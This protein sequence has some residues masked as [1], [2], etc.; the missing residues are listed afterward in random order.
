MPRKTREP[1]KRCAKSTWKKRP[2]EK[3]FPANFALSSTGFRIFNRV[4]ERFHRHLQ[5]TEHS[6]MTVNP[7]LR[8]LS[9]H[10]GLRLI[11]L[12][13][14]FAGFGLALPRI[15][16]LARQLSTNEIAFVRGVCFGLCLS[17]EGA[18]MRAAIF[19]NRNPE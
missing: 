13:L 8:R 4:H 5:A 7:P 10:T 16:E 2:G 11:A 1:G 17:V 3:E 19:G 14:L 12:G 15:P 6:A 9:R 18:G